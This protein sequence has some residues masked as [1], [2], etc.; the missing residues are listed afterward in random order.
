MFYLL[1]TCSVFV[2]FSSKSWSEAARLYEDVIQSM[3]DDT[4]DNTTVK[5]ITD[6]LSKLYARLAEMYREGGHGIERDP[7][8]SGDMYNSAAE[9]A[10]S[11][12]KGKLANKYFALAEEVWGEL[13]E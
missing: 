2:Y 9:N 3:E 1:L 12:M 5:L 10:M 4:T 7:Q 8:K 11:E 13:D 6:P